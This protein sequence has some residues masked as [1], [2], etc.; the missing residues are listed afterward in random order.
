MSSTPTKYGRRLS[1]DASVATAERAAAPEKR[2]TYDAIDSKGRRKPPTARTR[3]E[4]SI[5]NVGSRSKLSATSQDLV[6]NFAIAAWAVR[7]HCD[8][9]SIFDF[10]SQTGDAA[11]DAQIEWLMKRDNQPFYADAGNRF[12]REKMFRLAEVRRTVDGDVG[13]LKLNDGRLQGIESDRIRDP[14]SGKPGWINGVRVDDAGR[15]LAYGIH[16]RGRNGQGFEFDREVAASNLFHYGF[17]E[18]FASDQ[19]RGV[20]PIAAAINSFRDV[21]ENIDY[22]LIK[23]KVSQLFALVFYRDAEEAAGELTHDGS[24]NDDGGESRGGYQVDFGRGPIQLDLDPGDKAE[25]LESK[26]PSNEFQSFHSTVVMIALK[27]LD[28]PFSFF[29]ESHTNYSGSRGSW[30]QYDRS[31]HDKQADQILLRN[32]Y[33]IWKLQQWVRD[34]ELVLPRSWTIGDLNW[35]WVPKG[36]P[37][38]DPGKEVN[39]N[40]LAISAGLDNPQRI[41]KEHGRGDFKDNIDA[42]AD[43]MAYA[44][45]KGVPLSFVPTPQTVVNMPEG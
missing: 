28:I 11:L 23:A 3:S 32:R 27:S 6:R 13:L 2:F 20:S 39:A 31:C 19:V 33:T 16:R 5:L 12:T 43:A 8:Y 24:E 26:T 36:M 21:Y 30:L 25:F 9:V 45:E 29:D 15:A 44:K 14:D 17:F 10:H 18:R 40:L 34:G 22:A 4:D 38:F 41:V 37:W 35:E 1:F 42:I 7:R